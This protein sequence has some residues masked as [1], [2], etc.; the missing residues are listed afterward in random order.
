MALVT[1]YG[2]DTCPYTTAA[3]DHYRDKGTPVEYFNVKKNT[4]DLERM[5]GYSRGV[6]CPVIVEGNKVTIGFGGT[7]ESRARTGRSATADVVRNRHRLFGPIVVHHLHGL[8]GEH[9][10]SLFVHDLVLVAEARS[11]Y[12]RRQPDFEHVAIARGPF[13]IA[14][15]VREDHAWAFWP[16]SEDRQS[17]TA[18][19]NG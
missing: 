8:R 1:I 11:S 5:L 2:K 3:R 10:P 6:L 9:G 18:N 14:L 17:P 4:A 13:I 12:S 16:V 7:W 19:A 15:Y